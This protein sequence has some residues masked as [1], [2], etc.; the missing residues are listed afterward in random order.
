MNYAASNTLS[1]ELDVLWKRI[2]LPRLVV[3]TI[4]LVV[5]NWLAE[6]DTIDSANGKSGDFLFKLNEALNDNLSLATTTFGAGLVPAW[7]DVSFALNG[8]LT[9]T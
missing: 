8:A 4:Y 2:T 6:V 5:E 7:L 1:L 9:L 3:V